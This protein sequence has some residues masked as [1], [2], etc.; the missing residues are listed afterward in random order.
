MFLSQFQ[1][2]H[3]YLKTSYVMVQL[4][5]SPFDSITISGFKNIICYGSAVP[6]CGTRCESSKFKNIICYGSAMIHE[7]EMIVPKQFKNII[8]YG[9]AGA[10]VSD[11]TDKVGFKN[12]ICYG[13]ARL[14]QLNR[15]FVTYLKTSYVMVQQVKSGQ[16]GMFSIFK[17]IICYGSA[18]VVK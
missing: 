9:S 14:I 16:Y 10:I 2:I 6:T 11:L 12:I 7:G 18:E 13:S 1:L 17:N 15:L 4:P 8:C 5:M 3:L